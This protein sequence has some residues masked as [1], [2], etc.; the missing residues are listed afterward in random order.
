MN[1]TI[2]LNADIGESLGAW[3]LGSDT[4]LMPLLS[5]ANLACGFHAG[6]PRTM[7]RSVKL[8]LAHGVAIGAH[9]GFP[10]L[11]GFGRRDLAA[12]PEEVYTDVLYQIGALNAFVQAAGT[13]LH[14]VKPHGALYLRMLHDRAVAEAVSRAVF[15]S[16]PGSPLVGLA[17]PGGELMRRAAEKVGIRIVLEAFPD[18][19]YEADGRL[20]PR[21]LTGAVLHDPEE[22][23]QRA[24]QMAQAGT[25][26]ALT[27]ETVPLDAQTLCLHGDNPGATSAALA[28]RSAL[29]A[30]G[31]EVR[32]F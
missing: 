15:D 29:S 1:R 23:A 32:A 18:R 28:V 3:T 16:G 20:A 5:S 22:I 7:R 17:G 19:A 27:G 14:H 24:L 25:V 30:A 11:G 13:T 10:D 12:T 6:D 9:P 8:A 21:N 31:I 26:T 4:T 2:D